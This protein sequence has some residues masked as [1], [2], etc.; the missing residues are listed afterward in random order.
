MTLPTL[1]NAIIATAD[2]Q[3]LGHRLELYGLIEGIEP[4]LA[5]ELHLCNM[6]IQNH[7]ST[8]NKAIDELATLEKTLREKS[9]SANY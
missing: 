4:F 1:S 9:H 3:Y 7:V 6:E 8:L 2:L 5:T